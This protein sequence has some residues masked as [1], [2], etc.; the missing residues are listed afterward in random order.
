MGTDFKPYLTMHG[1]M[2]GILGT[3]TKYKDILGHPLAVG[4]TVEIFNRSGVSYGENVITDDGDQ[5]IM[6]IKSSCDG[7]AGT[8]G[9][10]RIVKKRGYKD[11]KNGERV[12]GVIYVTE[13]TPM[14]N[15]IPESPLEPKESRIHYEDPKFFCNQCDNTFGEEQDKFH[16]CKECEANA[17]KKFKDF[18]ETFTP[19]ERA[20]LN[21]HYDGQYL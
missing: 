18:M 3:P 11:I 5:Y 6:G 13:E 12:D 4:D 8:T 15:R 2:V 9:Y 17:L 20:L 21:W 10:W 16:L 19:A 14:D 7:K 1:E